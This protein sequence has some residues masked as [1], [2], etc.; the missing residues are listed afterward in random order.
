MLK[1]FSLHY[2][3]RAKVLLR[4]VVHNP[5]MELYLQ[6]K[7]RSLLVSCFIY[8]KERYFAV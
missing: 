2:K 5:S 4:H 6:I 7:S 1:E 8:I 3:S